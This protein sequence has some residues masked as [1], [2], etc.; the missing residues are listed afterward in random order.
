[1]LQKLNVLA[2]SGGKLAIHPLIV[3][4]Q[5]VYLDSAQRFVE[6]LGSPQPWIRRMLQDWSDTISAL[7]RI[8][9]TWLA[10]R[11]DAFA[12]YELYSNVLLDARSSWK[13][14]SGN[15]ELLVRLALL[16]QS[17]HEFCNPRSVFRQLE[18]SGAM[19]HRVD[20]CDKSGIEA[21]SVIGKL[22]TRARPRAA[23]IR[24]HQHDRS[25]IM[26]WSCVHDLPNRRWRDLMDPFAESY[27]PWQS[28]GGIWDLPGPLRHLHEHVAAIHFG[29]GR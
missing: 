26:D 25:L 21:E 20:D 5:R 3:Q 23:F 1:M 9:R 4:T 12:K 15:R 18:S 29:A 28:G 11:L 22:A 14:L 6:T 19:S 27:G 8:D 10:A 24:D 2:P 16:D 17:Y 13:T 7:E